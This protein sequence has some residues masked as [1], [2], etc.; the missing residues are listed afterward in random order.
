MRDVREI[1][2]WTFFDFREF[3]RGNE[4]GADDLCSHFIAF[5]VSMH[6]FITEYGPFG[7]ALATRED[8]QD[9]M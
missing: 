3:G 7:E 8:V 6:R 9:R 1:E 4:D 5:Y 2:N